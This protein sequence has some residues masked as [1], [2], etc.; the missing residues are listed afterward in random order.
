MTDIIREAL[1]TAITA[2]EIVLEEGTTSYPNTIAG[3]IS[4]LQTALDSLDDQTL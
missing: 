3:A 4:T 1:T 2:F